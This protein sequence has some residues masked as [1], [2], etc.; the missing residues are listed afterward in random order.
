MAQDT[1]SST[2]TAAGLDHL[3]PYDMPV[4]EHIVSAPQHAGGEHAHSHKR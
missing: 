2:A 4:D 3:C 1:A